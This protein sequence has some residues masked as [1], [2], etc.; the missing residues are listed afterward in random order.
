MP[1]QR[2]PMRQVREVLR[3]KYVCGHSGHQIAAMVGVSRYTVAEYLR[4]AAVVGITWPVPEALDDTAL[5]RKLFTPPF[6]S[7]A[8]RPQPD[9]PRMH[10][11]LRKPGVTLLL[12]WE[13]YR[14]GQP[15]GYGYSRF[16]DLARDW[17]GRLSPTMRQTH[18]AGE[19]MFVDYAGQTAEV[20]DNA[21]GE[22]RRAQVFVAVLGASNLTYAE[23][24]WTQSLPDWI[25]CHVGAFVSFGGVAR[26]IVCDNL[27]AGVT[28]ASRYE[29]GISRTYQDMA[30]HYGTAILPARV[31][32]PRD[33]AK[34]EVGVQVVQRWVLARLRH[35]RFFSLAELNGAIRELIADLNNRPMRHLGTSRRALFEAIEREAL[36]PMPQTP[37]DYAE[38]RRCR[39]GLDYHVQVYGHFYSVP[40]RLMREAVEARIT[41]QTIEL[42]HKNDRVACH[43]RDPRQHRHTTIPEHMP[44]AHRRHAEW[45]PT[46]LLREAQAI[47]PSTIALVERILTA[48]PHPEQG[49]RACLGILRLVRGYGPERLEAACQRGMD[50]GAQTYGSVNSILRNGLD[51]AYRPEPVPDELPV[52]HENIRGSGY[53]H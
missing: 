33:K 17:R 9:W 38:W 30:T 23:A 37:Y 48:K 51:R 50:I 36:L 22:V 41:D 16:C 27:K 6:T 45:T 44:S 52:Q 43:V 2:L 49:F 20:V 28:A 31:R 29:P 4:R 7:E 25:G 42:F 32:K 1:G 21:T 8:T 19:R 10:A 24:R 26:Q 15:D 12:L 47:G 39:A 40:Y 34:V 14:A 11:E 46:R 3:L 5:E 53:Y 18:P 35:R 13:E